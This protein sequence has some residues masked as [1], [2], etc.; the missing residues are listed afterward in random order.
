MYC[1][2]KRKTEKVHARPIRGFPDPAAD[3]PKSHERP[4]KE[5]R[6]TR[7]GER[8]TETRENIH[9]RR[10]RLPNW[11]NF[12]CPQS[13][14]FFPSCSY[15]FPW[16]RCFLLEVALFISS[17]FTY[18]NLVRLARLEKKRKTKL[19]HNHHVDDSS[20]HF[21]RGPAT[22]RWSLF[23]SLS[24]SLCLSFSSKGPARYDFYLQR[25]SFIHS[26]SAFVKMFSKTGLVLSLFALAKLAAAAPP[27]CLLAAVK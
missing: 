5:T 15:S 22:G 27:A 12:F 10:S 17:F 25:H 21:T 18:I 8:E 16:A 14:P 23:N 26:F 7:A 9:F 20:F 11:P 1:N 6:L 19:F 13:L 4:K 3:R 2:E 24:L